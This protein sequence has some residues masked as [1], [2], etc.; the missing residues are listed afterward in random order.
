MTVEDKPETKMA[1][2]LL[3]WMGMNATFVS[4]ESSR[5]AVLFADI[6]IVFGM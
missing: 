1:F 5:K 4:K 3:Y 6:R 2:L